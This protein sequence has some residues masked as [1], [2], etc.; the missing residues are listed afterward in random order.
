MQTGAGIRHPLGE[1]VLETQEDDPGCPP[2]VHT[3]FRFRLLS[4]VLNA[5]SHLLL[6]GRRVSSNIYGIN[7]FLEPLSSS[8]Y[9]ITEGPGAGPEKDRQ[10]AQVSEDDIILTSLFGNSPRNVHPSLLRSGEA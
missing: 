3:G 8:W 2:G 1:P 4:T 7:D 10:K 6:R 5:S 9:D